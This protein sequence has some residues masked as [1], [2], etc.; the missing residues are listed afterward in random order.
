M[1]IRLI[2]IL[3][4]ALLSACG[5]AM[6]V[7][8]QGPLPPPGPG[9]LPFADRALD[10]TGTP[11]PS[12]KSLTQ[13]DP[14]QPIPS[15]D[16]NLPALTG[17]AGN[18]TISRPGH[19]YLT[20]NLTRQVVIDADDV[21]LDLRG[22]LIEFVPSLEVPPGTQVAVDGGSGAAAHENITVRNGHIKGAWLMGVRLGKTCRVHG[23]QVSNVNTYGILCGQ[24]AAVEECTVRAQR[25]EAG[26]P[27]G[28]GPWSGIHCDD[29]SVVRGCVADTIRA[30]GILAQSGSRIADCVAISCYGCGIVSASGS[31]L[32]G[33]TAKSCGATGID[34]NTGVSLLNCSALG[35]RNEGFHLRGG[36]ALMNC[37]SRGNLE[38]GYYAERST[39]VGNP[40]PPENNVAVS[41]VQCVAQLN[42]WDGFHTEFDC[43]FTHCSADK[44]GS[45]PLQP[46]QTPPPLTGTSHGFNV[47]DGCQ[48]LNCLSVA[49]YASGYKG[50]NNNRMEGCTA[51][52]NGTWG[53]ELASNQNVVIRNFVRSNGTGQISVPAGNGVAPLTDAAAATPTS[54]LTF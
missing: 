50:G 24:S 38:E 35:N 41:F 1:N 40:L 4:M 17:S 39:F 37:T 19:Y 21:T 22:Y 2:P 3:R 53:I 32:S 25:L 15:R 12:M 13:T 48:F 7:L 42:Q 18:Y 43:L 51:R 9:S 11:V 29:G 27:A 34:V 8:G 20:E 10:A 52:A 14:G 5:L 49:N 31:S 16:A 6:P 47:T 26:A 36:C 45:P 23:L 54:N 28:P 46:G 44:N 30:I 33:C